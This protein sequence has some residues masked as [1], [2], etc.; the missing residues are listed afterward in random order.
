MSLT[1]LCT[2]YYALADRSLVAPTPAVVQLPATAR[3]TPS[4]HLNPGGGGK[5][6]AILATS[7]ASTKAL[8]L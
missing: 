1:L 8:A 3:H 7:Q 5:W 2:P 4:R 6:A